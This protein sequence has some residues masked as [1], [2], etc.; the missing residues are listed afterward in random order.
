MSWMLLLEM[1]VDQFEREVDQCEPYE[2][3]QKPIHQALDQQSSGRGLAA[4]SNP[5]FIKCCR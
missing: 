3:P 5:L 4:C 2:L 1:P